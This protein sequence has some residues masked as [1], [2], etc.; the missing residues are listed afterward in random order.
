[1]DYSPWEHRVG[2]NSAH[3]RG[4]V[5]VVTTACVSGGKCYCYLLVRG[6][7]LFSH[8]VVSDSLRPD[9]LQHARDAAKHPTGQRAGPQPRN[10]CPQMP[11]GCR[12]RNPGMELEAHLKG[13]D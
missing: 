8:S 2:Y 13:N 5:F 3:T 12:L 11:A 10:T 4:Q 6:Q 7:V 9:G 1:M